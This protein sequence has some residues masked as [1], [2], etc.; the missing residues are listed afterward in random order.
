M[1]LFGNV[2]T[3]EATFRECANAVEKAGAR[4]VYRLC[5]RPGH[6]AHHTGLASIV[7]YCQASK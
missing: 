4:A 1:L 6:R 2:S 7:S 5:F 3:T